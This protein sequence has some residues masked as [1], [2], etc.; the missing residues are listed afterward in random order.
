MLK[1]ID[2]ESSLFAKVFGY[3][4][5]IMTQ[6]YGESVLFAFLHNGQILCEWREWQGNFQFSI[7]GGKIDP[8]DRQQTNYQQASLMRE[9]W[10]EFQVTPTRF[11]RIGETLY[12][13]KEWLFHVYMIYAWDG[14]IPQTVLD[15]QRPV[16]WIDPADL[17]DNIAMNGISTLIR[18]HIK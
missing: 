18:A 3:T 11:A 6:N 12:A 10:E 14:Q 9:I 1:I 17:E 8:I 4:S 2:S 16:S 13:E 7:P 15:S 5:K